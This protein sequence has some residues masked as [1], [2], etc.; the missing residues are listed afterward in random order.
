VHCF[1]PGEAV[2]RGQQAS[3]FLPGGSLVLMF[4]KKDMFNP[5]GEILTQTAKGFE[6]KISAG[7]P[8]GTSLE[9]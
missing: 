7:A 5:C 6:S 1:E 4:F 8:I 2:S 3:Y 9:M